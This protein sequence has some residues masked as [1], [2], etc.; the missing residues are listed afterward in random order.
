MI[1]DTLDNAELY[2]NLHRNLKKA[3]E[4]IFD[5]VKNNKPA[6][7]YEIEGEEVFA[8]VQEYETCAENEKK[9]ESHEK[10]IDLQYVAAGAE[11][12]GWGLKADFKPSC[13]YDEQKD[14]VFYKDSEGTRVKVPARGFAVFFPEDIHKPGCIWKN[15]TQVKKI[16]VKIKV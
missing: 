4:F 6:G 16:V 15:S 14:I 8:L 13:E 10:Y 7:R 12:M 11:G 9:W 3:F 1:A 5:Y 2:Y